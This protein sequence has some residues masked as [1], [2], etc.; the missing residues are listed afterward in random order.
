M[1]T[2][3]SSNPSKAP[4][5][6]T[7]LGTAGSSSDQIKL[8]WSRRSIF[9]KPELAPVPI[10]PY[11]NLKKTCKKTCKRQF[12]A[13]TQALPFLRTQLQANGKIFRCGLKLKPFKCVFTKTSWRHF[14]SIQNISRQASLHLFVCSHFHR[15]ISFHVW[16]LQNEAVL[17]THSSRAKIYLCA[18]IETWDAAATKPPIIIQIVARTPAAGCKQKAQATR[19]THFAAAIASRA[20]A[21]V[22]LHFTKSS[23]GWA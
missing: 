1:P 22:Y 7:A 4:E 21:E 11:K 17:K 2:T 18:P 3:N 19:K 12:L 5:I 16:T 13:Q 14:Y 9:F 10:H 15:T 23:F 20:W 6:L 8:L